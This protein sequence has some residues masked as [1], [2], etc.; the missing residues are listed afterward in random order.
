MDIMNWI[1][2]WSSVYIVIIYYI[3]NY[4]DYTLNI[5]LL[6]GLIDMPLERGD[7]SFGSPILNLIYKNK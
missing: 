7:F 5:M 2:V 3:P 4:G 6:F 1:E